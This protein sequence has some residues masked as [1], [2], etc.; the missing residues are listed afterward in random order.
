[1]WEFLGGGFAEDGKNEF[2]GSSCSYCNNLD[3]KL[4]GLE[5]R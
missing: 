5:L 1:M 2:I 3:I 4:Q